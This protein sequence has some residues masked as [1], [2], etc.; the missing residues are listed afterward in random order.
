MTTRI[1]ES[2]KDLIE[3]PIVST[4]ATITPEGRPHTTII[5]RYFDGEVIRFITSRGLQ[6]E[7]N[8]QAHPQ[9]SLMTLD[10]DNVGRYVEIRGVV[11]DISETGAIEALNKMT[12]YYTGQPAYYGHIVPAENEGTRT[13]VICR[14]RIE[15]V[16]TH[17]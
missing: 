4:L 3:S 15:K 1:P 5:W 9:I 17:G 13:H 12:Q 10:P 8:M 11:E 2:H 16:I 14:I 6:K 7:K